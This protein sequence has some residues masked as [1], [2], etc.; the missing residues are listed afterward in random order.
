[1]LDPRTHRPCYRI[2]H[3]TREP[4]RHR[5]HPHPQPIPVLRVFFTFVSCLPRGLS[6]TNSSPFLSAARW[7]SP[8]LPRLPHCTDAHRDSRRTRLCAM[9]PPNGSDAFGQQAQT[10][11]YGV[12]LTT[13]NAHL[14]EE[15][16]AP[17]AWFVVETSQDVDKI[18]FE[19]RTPTGPFA[20]HAALAA[21]N[22]MLNDTCSLSVSVDRASTPTAVSIVHVT[23]ATSSHGGGPPRPVSGGSDG[24]SFPEMPP[25]KRMRH[26]PF[27]RESDQ[28]PV[29]HY[30]S[31]G[32]ESKTGVTEDSGSEP[33]Q[34]APV[35]GGRMRFAVNLLANAVCEENS[36]T[37]TAPPGKNRSLFFSTMSYS[38]LSPQTTDARPVGLKTLCVQGVTRVSES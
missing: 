8:P 26:A 21:H 2:S 31:T 14:V 17:G 13:P 22:R 20:L 37:T 19:H 7:P 10:L 32:N 27:R 1:M 12:H 3:T 28:S 18:S 16:S 5:A 11:M 38:K 30:P 6:C 33:R 29:Q 36:W 9:P 34:D 25:C 35:A 23:D 24:C 4:V 15:C